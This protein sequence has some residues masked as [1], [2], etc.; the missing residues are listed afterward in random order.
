M[1]RPRLGPNARHGLGHLRAEIVQIRID[2]SGVETNSCRLSLKLSD[3]GIQFCR[4]DLD[5]DSRLVRNAGGIVVRDHRATNKVHRGLRQQSWQCNK[6][7]RCWHQH[8]GGHSTEKVGTTHWNLDRRVRT[9]SCESGCVARTDATR[10]G[11]VEV[12]LPKGV[13]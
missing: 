5:K 13:A 10:C 12:H 11:D 7:S 4:G 9:T 1:Q 8:Q 2:G 6:R 3:G